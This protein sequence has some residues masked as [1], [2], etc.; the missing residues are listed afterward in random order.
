MTAAR[1]QAMAAINKRSVRRSQIFDR[2]TAVLKQNPRVAARNF[3]FRIAGIKI[4]VGE[5]AAFGVPTADVRFLIVQ[6]ELLA[7][8]VAAFDYQRRVR[9]LTAVITVQWR[10]RFGDRR[11]IR[12][13]PSSSTGLPPN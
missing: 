1:R 10:A 7:G 12:R 11:R 2:V 8:R 5:N 6:K 3:C 13:A 4:H 9:S